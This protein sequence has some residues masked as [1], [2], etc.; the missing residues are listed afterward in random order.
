MCLRDRIGEGER[1]GERNSIFESEIVNL[2]RI[3][4]K[5]IKL[6]LSLST[7]KVLIENLN[8][9]LQFK[10]RNFLW[11]FLFNFLTMQLL[12][13]KMFWPPKFLFCLLLAIYH[14]HRAQHLIEWFLT[15]S[16]FLRL[17]L[18]SFFFNL[19]ISLFLICLST[20]VHCLLCHSFCHLLYDPFLVPRIMLILLLFP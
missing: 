17:L 11:H 4:F 19:F 18:F 15:A 5:V 10:S 20:S 13:W 1:D 2:S 9:S 7:K 14:F 3:L 6:T 8:Q 16:S 12:I